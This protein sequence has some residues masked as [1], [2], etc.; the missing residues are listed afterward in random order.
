GRP[1][2]PELGQEHRAGALPRAPVA[3]CLGLGD[4]RAAPAVG[5]TD[6]ELVLE[7]DEAAAV[8]ELDPVGRRSHDL[9]ALVLR[10]SDRHADNRASSDAAQLAQCRLVAVLVTPALDL[11]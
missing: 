4:G 7:D 3:R 11:V 8:E 10:D 6:V 9:P 1:R 2:G 5:S